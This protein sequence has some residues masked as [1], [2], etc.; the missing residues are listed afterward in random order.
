MFDCRNESGMDKGL[1]TMKRLVAGSALLAAISTSAMATDM[2]SGFQTLPASAT[3]APYD[4]SGFYGGRSSWSVPYDTLIAGAPVPSVAS[5][6]GTSGGMQL[7]YNYQNGP[8]VFGI[9]GEFTRRSNLDSILHAPAGLVTSRDEQGWFG[10]LRPRAGIAADHW[11]FY[12]TGGLAYGSVR[13]EG[14]EALAAGSTPAGSDPS[15]RAGWTVGGGISFAGGK[16]WSLGL[17]YL[18]TDFGKGLSDTPLTPFTTAFRDQSHL[19]RGRF[20]YQFDWSSLPQAL[21]QK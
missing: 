7:G 19:V 4:W 8:F 18:Y 20:N 14:T 11:L 1:A 21:P 13:P 9:E 15:A 3:E 12:A 2:S 10:M 6:S 17:E 5:P 16:R